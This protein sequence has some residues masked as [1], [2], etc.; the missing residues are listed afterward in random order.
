M[1]VLSVVHTP[2]LHPHLVEEDGEG[3]NLRGQ[4]NHMGLVL[5]LDIV[6]CILVVDTAAKYTAVEGIVAAHMCFG[7]NLVDMAGRSFG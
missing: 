2:D 4:E 7:H 5:E 6:G 1:V 3:L